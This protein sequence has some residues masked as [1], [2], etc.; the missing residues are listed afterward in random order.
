L[1]PEQEITEV[2][3]KEQI[4]R[5]ARMHKYVKAEWFGAST[6]GRCCGG[7]IQAAIECAQEL[8]LK[9]L[10]LPQ[11]GT[12]HFFEIDDLDTVVKMPTKKSYTV[13]GRVK[14]VGRG[15]PT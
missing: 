7:A 11:S 2:I 15:K 5:K 10:R 3:D 12:Y 8:G 9:N 14:S 13:K 6:D 4:Y 1:D